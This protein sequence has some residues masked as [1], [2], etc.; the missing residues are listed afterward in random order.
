M[1]NFEIYS[2]V[3][4]DRAWHSYR[5]IAESEAGTVIDDPVVL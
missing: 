5:S 4:L 2:T 3:Q 1:H